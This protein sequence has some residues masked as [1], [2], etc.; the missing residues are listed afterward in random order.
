MAAPMAAPQAHPTKQI[1]LPVKAPFSNADVDE[2]MLVPSETCEYLID[3]SGS[4]VVSLQ[5]T[6]IVT[7]SKAGEVILDTGGW[8]T[9]ETLDGMNRVLKHI[10]V[11]V[12]PQGDPE[13]GNW[14][15]SFKGQ[16][17]RMNS[18]GFKLAAA[19]GTERRGALVV[20]SFK[21]AEIALGGDSASVL[22]RLHKQ[23]RY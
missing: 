4:V 15:V 18:D 8:W 6:N 14:F 22:R 5:G 11:L 10:G 9:Q 1:A 23:G 3:D 21:T 19:G 2:A 13:E 17:R 12:K 16:A 20:A 7:I